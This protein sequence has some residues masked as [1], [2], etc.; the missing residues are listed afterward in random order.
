MDG[1]VRRLFRVLLFVVLMLGVMHFFPRELSETIDNRFD[2][3]VEANVPTWYSTILLFSVSLSCISVYI[4][5]QKACNRDRFWRRFW[6]IMG[7]GYGF[8]SLDEAAR[9][10][11][12]INVMLSTSWT[13]VYA[14]FA[15]VFFLLCVYYFAVVRGAD[16]SLRNW[17]LGGLIVYALGGLIS[18]AIGYL[19]WPLPPVLYGLELVSEECL[20]MTGTIMV[21]RGCLQESMRLFESARGSQENS[22]AQLRRAG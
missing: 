3:D 11:E 8:L 7:V 18:E 21:L 19:Y 16:K 20:E 15:G 14:P 5:A 13:F 2:L 6:L 9:L 22:Q 12:V 1:S 4:Q 10:H 17:I